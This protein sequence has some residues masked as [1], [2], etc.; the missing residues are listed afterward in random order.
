M[1]WECAVF[2]SLFFE[3]R[4]NV[5]E[6]GRERAGTLSFLDILWDIIGDLGND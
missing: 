4:D 3:R 2:L 6:G 1:A 5:G